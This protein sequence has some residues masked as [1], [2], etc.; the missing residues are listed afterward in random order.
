MNVPDSHTLRRRQ[1][2]I[3][4]H[5]GF[6]QEHVLHHHETL[7]ENEGIDVEPPDG[8]RAHHIERLQLPAARLDHLGQSQTGVCGTPS[9]SSLNFPEL[10][11]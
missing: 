10:L 6:R 9:H 7:R 3:G 2:D 8:I 4:E 5:G 11:H 1:N